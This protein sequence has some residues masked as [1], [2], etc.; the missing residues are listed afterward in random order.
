VLTACHPIE[1]WCARLRREELDAALISVAGMTVPPRLGATR[2][3][4]ECSSAAGLWLNPAL[5]GS[6]IT[7]I[8]LGR[9]PLVLIHANDR[10]ATT[11][12]APNPKARR[13]WRLLLPPAEHQ[14]L[15]WRQLERLALLPLRDC[16][17][18]DSESWLQELLQGPHLLPA[19]LS[20][21]E[22]EPWSDA[23][24]KAVPPPEPLE[25][26]LWLLVRQEADAEPLVKNLA[27]NIRSRILQGN[28]SPP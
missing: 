14:P 19:H 10:Q 26:S 25:E 13:P 22:E 6:D 12:P 1:S 23:D 17:A 9:R 18:A 2:A 21:L 7:A 15:L 27:G 16:S 28:G 11:D 5:C 20:L 3:R 24:L 8:S 4:P